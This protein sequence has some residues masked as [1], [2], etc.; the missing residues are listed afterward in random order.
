MVRPALCLLA[1]LA[2]TSPDAAPGGPLTWRLV[3]ELRIGGAE[4][5]PES[6]IDV[7]SI[8]VDGAGR[9]HILDTQARQIR[10]FDATGDHIRTLGR[11]GRGPGEFV[12]PNGMGF[13]PDGT[14]LVYDAR[15][16]RVT[17]FDSSGQVVATE[18]LPIYSFGYLW[19]G[20]V[21]TAGRIIDRIRLP[22]PE[23][24]ARLRRTDLATGSADTLALH[25]CGA[26]AVPAYA[27]P[28]GFASVPF[29]GGPVSIVDP[30]GYTWCADTR[31]YTVLQRRIGSADTVRVIRGTASPVPVTAAERDSAVAAIGEFMK[32]VG[33]ADVDWSLIPD[34]KPI[35]EALDVDAAGRL[36]VRVATPEHGTRFDVFDSTGA[37][38]ATAAA[39]VELPRHLHPVIRGDE[40]YAVVLDSLDV[41]SVV[42]LRVDR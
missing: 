17:A 32:D 3:E 26:P 42:R 6:F 23:R 13:A 36:W 16:D 11:D 30:R 41:P 18:P 28:R 19:D 33:E 20:I 38:V 21:D 25:S 31:E 1:C 22:G 7:R 39:A 8:A 24:E 15:A 9:I 5:G 4:T 34:H 27:F 2:C 40:L 10:V 29:A 12:L 14:L 37:Q 35:L